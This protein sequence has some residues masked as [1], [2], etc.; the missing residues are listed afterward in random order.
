MHRLI[1]L[2]VL[3]LSGCAGA[4]SSRPPESAAAEP[5][6]KTLQLWTERVNQVRVGMRRE[7]VERILPRARTEYTESTTLSGGAQGVQY[8]VA[9][10]IKVTIFYDY[11]GTPRGSLSAVRSPDNR[12]IQAPVLTCEPPT[13][14][15][16]K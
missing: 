11:T 9:P 5:T 3:A 8:Y 13:P 14:A 6:Q 2:F 12:V 7:E 1:I 15:D 4:W 16:G 10:G